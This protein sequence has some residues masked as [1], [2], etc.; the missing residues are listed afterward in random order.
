MT[1]LAELPAEIEGNIAMGLFPMPKEI[2]GGKRGMALHTRHRV[3]IHQYD[4]HDAKRLAET[5]SELYPLDLEQ[6][7]AFIDE[8]E[9]E[10]LGEIVT[11]RKFYP[12]KAATEPRDAT[13]KP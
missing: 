6:F 8:I 10:N 13:E 9:Q 5:L 3:V 4:Y 12:C 11:D 2:E 7:I 1:A